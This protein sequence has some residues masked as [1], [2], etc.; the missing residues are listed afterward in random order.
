MK[1]VWPVVV[2][3]LRNVQFR[4]SIAMNSLSF[5]ERTTSF[6]RNQRMAAK[7]H[8][9]IWCGL[10]NH[11]I[12]KNV[13]PSGP[14][15]QNTNLPMH[16]AVMTIDL[17][18]ALRYGDQLN[19]VASDD[20]FANDAQACPKRKRTMLFTFCAFLKRQYQVITL[21]SR[22]ETKGNVQ[23]HKHTNE[24][25]YVFRHLARRSPDMRTP[26]GLVSSTPT[27]PDHYHL[28]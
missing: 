11:P 3:D 19:V 9:S 21:E 25:G 7:E 20:I 16:N 6:C 5:K 4:P 28:R 17:G 23:P 15:I 14:I 26:R 24:S 1:N 27:Q 2:C 12:I 13:S 22:P 18:N 10:L 8:I